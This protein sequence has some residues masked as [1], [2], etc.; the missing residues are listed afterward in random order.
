MCK[1][2]YLKG[3]Q[4]YKVRDHCPYTGEYSGA[5]HGMCYLK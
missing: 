4:Y 5:G 1:N 3:K 2:K